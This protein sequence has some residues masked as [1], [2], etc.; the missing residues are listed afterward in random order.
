MMARLPGKLNPFLA[1]PSS[2]KYLPALP[3]LPRV[4]PHPRRESFA[5]Q[6]ELLQA[7]SDPEKD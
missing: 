1:M 4:E 5:R 7:A 2:D 3:P 6:A